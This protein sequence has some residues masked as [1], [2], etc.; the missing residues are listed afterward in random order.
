MLLP[1]PYRVCFILSTPLLSDCNASFFEDLFAANNFPVCSQEAEATTLFIASLVDDIQ[2]DALSNAD[3]LKWFEMMAGNKYTSGT[4]CKFHTLLL[5]AMLLLL[6][7][8][9]GTTR[10]K[11]ILISV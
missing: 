5:K 1:N 4:S 10:S 7:D 8:S 11:Q 6:G 2:P 9:C 3:I